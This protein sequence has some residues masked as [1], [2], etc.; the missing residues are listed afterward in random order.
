MD[1]NEEKGVEK[2]NTKDMVKIWHYFNK[3]YAKYIIVVNESVVI[4][5]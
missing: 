4:Y 3:L 2:Q 5:N 1:G